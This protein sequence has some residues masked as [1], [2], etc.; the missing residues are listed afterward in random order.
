MAQISAKMEMQLISFLVL[1]GDAD[2]HSIEFC[3]SDK[4]Q[5]K[6]LLLNHQSLSDLAAS[7]QTNV[8]CDKKLNFDKHLEENFSDSSAKFKNSKI[9]CF[10]RRK[11]A[12]DSRR[13]KRKDEKS[14][15]KTDLKD[16][17]NVE[18]DKSKRNKNAVSYTHLTLPTIYS[19]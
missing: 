1:H 15:L 16:T 19:V 17:E 10:R 14:K 11:P 13:R 6:A 12:T 9:G 2:F 5:L 7:G 4:D 18:A 3:D 8:T